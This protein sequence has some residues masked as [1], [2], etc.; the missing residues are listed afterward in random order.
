M[1]TMYVPGPLEEDALDV[2]GRDAEGL[3]LDVFGLEFGIVG[4][5]C[6]NFELSGTGRK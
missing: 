6:D 5:S 4:I 3:D 1:A 2:P